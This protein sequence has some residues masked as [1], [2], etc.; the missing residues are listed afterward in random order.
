MAI[1]DLVFTIWSC[2][3]CGETSDEDGADEAALSMAGAAHQAQT[4]HAVR[5]ERL[6]ARELTE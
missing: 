1:W 2:S 6:Y 4:G 3:E 5:L